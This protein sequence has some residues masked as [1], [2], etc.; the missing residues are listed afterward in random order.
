MLAIMLALEEWRHTLLELKTFLRSGQI[1][2]TSNISVNHRKLTADKPDGS[3]NSHN[4][5][6]T[7]HHKPGTSNVKPDFLSR[8]LGLDKG[9][10]DNENTVLLP[11]H[12]FRSLHLNLQGAKYLLEPS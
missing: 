2:K 9:E 7:L 4:I 11:E 12:H 8:P 1:I 5:T 10:N 6:F 3:Q